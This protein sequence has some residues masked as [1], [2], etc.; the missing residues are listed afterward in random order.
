MTNPA[1]R[2]KSVTNQNLS[3]LNIAEKTCRRDFIGLSKYIK[4]K[5]NFN[6]SQLSQPIF[7]SGRYHLNSGDFPN[8]QFHMTKVWSLREELN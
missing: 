4:G 5:G 8:A 3:Q 6:I 7:P 1:A 2:T